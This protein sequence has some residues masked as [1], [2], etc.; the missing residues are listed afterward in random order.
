MTNYWYQETGS[1]RPRATFQA[2]A[3]PTELSRYK[4]VLYRYFSHNDCSV[5]VS[6][7]DFEGSFRRAHNDTIC[8]L[9]KHIKNAHI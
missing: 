8:F 1:N 4:L 6:E 7:Q 2:A 3:L 5:G 9:F